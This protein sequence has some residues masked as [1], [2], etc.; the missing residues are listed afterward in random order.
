VHF[1]IG[2]RQLDCYAAIARIRM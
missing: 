1:D 2:P